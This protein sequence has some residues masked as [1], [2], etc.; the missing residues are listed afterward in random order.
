M[1][2]KAQTILS[3]RE[4]GAKFLL[5]TARWDCDKLGEDKGRDEKKTPSSS[6]SQVRPARRAIT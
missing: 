5:D 1:L 2:Y 3:K 4:C 6:P